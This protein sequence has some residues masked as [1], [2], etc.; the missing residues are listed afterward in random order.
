MYDLLGND[1][2]VAC[3]ST[4][5]KASLEGM[6]KVTEVRFKLAHQNFCNG[7][8]QSV[9]KTNGAKLVDSFGFGVFRDKA[10]KGGV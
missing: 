10:K 3:V 7:F 4:Q 8:V 9:T 2:V 5:N 6:N 1:D